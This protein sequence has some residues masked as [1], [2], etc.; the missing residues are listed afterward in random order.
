MLC[1]GK[2]AFASVTTRQMQAIASFMR[3]IYSTLDDRVS[4]SR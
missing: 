2:H 3:A 1:P 4:I